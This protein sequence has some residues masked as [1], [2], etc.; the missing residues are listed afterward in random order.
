M[1]L[2][3]QEKYRME[4]KV[5]VML[6]ST[7]I[8]DKDSALSLNKQKNGRQAVIFYS[9]RIFCTELPVS[10]YTVTK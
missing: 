4:R 9:M 10:V 1:L 7:I 5:V 3:A 2:E 8:I 6:M